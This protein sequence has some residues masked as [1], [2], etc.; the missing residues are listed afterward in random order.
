MLCNNKSQILN[1]SGSGQL[2][3]QGSGIEPLPSIDIHPPQNY[4]NHKNI[5][6]NNSIDPNIKVND[7]EEILED[8]LIDEKSKRDK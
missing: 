7:S 3:G 6:T 8:Y 1:K 5:K 4:K 2:L